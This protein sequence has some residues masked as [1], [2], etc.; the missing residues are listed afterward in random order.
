MYR[1]SS[2]MNEGS[3]YGANDP[4]SLKPRLDVHEK[5]IELVGMMHKA[6]VQIMAL[7][8]LGLGNGARVD[9]H[10]ELALLAEAGF[11]PLERCRLPR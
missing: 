7:R 11:S 4:E 8:F 3:C 5:Q 1:L 10:N 2:P 6:V 9:L